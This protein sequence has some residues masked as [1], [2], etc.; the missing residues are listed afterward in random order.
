MYIF[1]FFKSK[2]AVILVLF[3]LLTACNVQEFYVNTT[4]LTSEDYYNPQAFVYYLPASEVVVDIEAVKVVENKGPYADYAKEFLGD[5][6]N[7]IT[8]NK[9]YW[10]L[11]NI[12]IGT[13]P[14]RDTNSIWKVVSTGD[15]PYYL[16]L[17]PEGFPVSINSDLEYDNHGFLTQSYL[18]RSKKT[19]STETL[20][21]V[22]QGYKEVYDTIFKVETYDT[23]QRTVPIIEKRLIKKSRRDQAREL[24]DK[25]FTLRDDREAL[26]VG[27][28]DSEYLPDGDALRIM[29]E[30]IDKLEKEYLAQFIG[31]V[32]QTIYHYRFRFTPQPT[33]DVIQKIIFRFSPKYGVLPADDLRGDPVILEIQSF[34]TTEK[35][36]G[37]YSQMPAAIDIVSGDNVLSN[38]F[39]YR[40]PEKV[41]VQVK[42][43]GKVLAEREVLM[44]QFGTYGF[45][46]AKIF[47][48]SMRV[49]F[50]PD[51]GAIKSIEADK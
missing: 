47:N 33:N 6:A 40:I 25:I 20:L 38:G 10:K 4:K 29:L 2:L 1:N 24:A 43:D 5:L 31:R 27:E 50:Y 46:P 51:L 7:L 9:T 26:L 34:N 48:S 41:R 36:A 17:T 13:T 18:D 30:G 3:A 32:D 15:L 37:F 35:I 39:V 14:V 22:D 11:S 21:I 44:A 45:L 8:E 49:E 16:Q 12:K 19:D 23:I 28:G 42:Q